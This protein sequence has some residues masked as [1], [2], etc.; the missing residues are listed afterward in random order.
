P[1][2]SGVGSRRQQVGQRGDN[3]TK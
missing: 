1:P 3:D 2:P